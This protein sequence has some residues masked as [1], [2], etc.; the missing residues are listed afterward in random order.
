MLRKKQRTRIKTRRRK[1]Y[2]TR[3]KVNKKVP[4]PRTGTKYVAKALSHSNQGIPVVVAV[5]DLLGLAKTSREVKLMVKAKKIK[6]NG[7]VVK[8]IREGVRIFN[9]LE[10]GKVYKLIATTSGRIAFEETKDKERVTK[11]IGKKI[12]K[13]GKIQMNLHD[14]TNVLTKDNVNVG[15]SVYLDSE[16]KVAKNVK[17]EKGKEVFI[18]SGRSVGNIGKI[19]EVSE[20][21]IHVQLEERE[22]DLDKS[23]I[24]VL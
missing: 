21:K 11:I 3:S 8:D 22:V 13:N 17:M 10:V 12:L 23:H 16:N 14:G 5:R 24:I 1:M 2:L 6:L 7:K 4:I 15:D 19:K 9:L 20:K 18:I